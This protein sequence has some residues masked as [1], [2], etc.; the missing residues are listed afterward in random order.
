MYL[1]ELFPDVTNFLLRAKQR[2]DEVFI[3]SHKTEYGHYDTEKIL[4]REEAMRWLEVKNFFGSE[5]LGID[6]DH[7]FF[8]NTRKEKVGKIL[9]LQ[10]DVFIDDLW[11]V[12]NE[13]GFPFKTKKILFVSHQ[14]NKVSLDFS[15]KSWREISRFLL[16]A[17]T[18]SEISYWL[19]YWLG[20]SPTHFE[21][22]PGR[23]NSQVFLMENKQFRCA[24]KWYPDLSIDSRKRLQIEKI[25]SQF[26]KENKFESLIQFVNA[27]PAQYSSVS[28]V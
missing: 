18:D 1:A 28:L 17:E 22:L 20:E 14:A 26:L 3:V 2:G 7:V 19:T 16:G 15:S 6:R 21:R 24:I 5:G 13:P 8:A 12:F 4:L 9:S 27:A 11:E 10:C 23:A 25:A